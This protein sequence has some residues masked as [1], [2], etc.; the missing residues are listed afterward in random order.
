VDGESLFPDEDQEETVSLDGDSIEL[1]GGY[2]VH[3]HATISRLNQDTEDNGIF[4]FHNFN[5]QDSNSED[6][7]VLE[8]EQVFP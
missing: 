4:A 8:T 1:E 5:A 7:R 6:Y 2:C 3:I